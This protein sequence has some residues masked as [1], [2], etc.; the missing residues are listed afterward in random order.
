MDRVVAVTRMSRAVAG[1]LEAG[2]GAGPSGLAAS[3]E[4]PGEDP[5][6][7]NAQPARSSPLK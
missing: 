7:S 3:A 4:P 6:V 1:R 2:S 5:P